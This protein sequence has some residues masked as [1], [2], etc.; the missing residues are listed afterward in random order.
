M[1]NVDLLF[2]GILRFC[3]IAFVM[4]TATQLT[5]R[6]LK[7]PLERIRLIQ[8][9]LLALFATIFAGVAGV[10]PSIEFAMLPA[11]DTSQNDSSVSD[12]AFFRFRIVEESGDEIKDASVFVLYDSE[13][14]SEKKSDRAAMMENQIGFDSGVKA[15]RISSIV[16]GE[17]LTFR[18]S[19][20]GFRSLSETVTMKEGE[21]RT[22]TLTLKPG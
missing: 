1:S 8:I 16:P 19:R 6:L 20:S 14:D 22:I 15:F 13:N 3:A 17:N 4:L 21:R 9:S 7:Q 10:V 5:L 12:A 18:A 11:A 2:V